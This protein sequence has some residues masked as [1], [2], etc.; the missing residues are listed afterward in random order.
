MYKLFIIFIV[1]IQSIALAN[2]PLTALFTDTINN[3]DQHISKLKIMA[4]NG[5]SKAQKELGDIYYDSIHEYKNAIKWYRLAAN[6]GNIDAQ[7]SLIDALKNATYSNIE[8]LTWL[9]LAAKAGNTEAL[10]D[11]GFFYWDQNNYKKAIETLHLAADKGDESAFSALAKL[12]VLVDD[13]TI[14]N[15]NKAEY[16]LDKIHT[17][18]KYDAYTMTIIADKYFYG[19]M[20]DMDIDQAIKWYKKSAML[21]NKDATKK[22]VSIYSQGKEAP[23]NLDESLKWYKLS[24]EQERNAEEM[25]HLAQM[26]YYGDEVKQDLE[27]AFIWY[28]K[29]ADNNNKQASRMVGEMYFLGKG[30]NKNIEFALYYLLESNYDDPTTNYLTKQIVF[31]ESNP[32]KQTIDSAIKLYDKVC[33]LG[34]LSACFK[35]SDLLR[36]NDI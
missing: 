35:Q 28:K 23:E 24:I 34:S 14:F 36:S 31:G 29:A 33:K 11:L 5:N 13:P 32:N 4:Q 22:L 12:Y 7:L 20:V 15:I 2:Q 1:V 17:L 21:G 16:F 30:T 3:S 9:K 19:D 27:E 8:Y 26:Y 6:Q 18:G 10:Y 25:L